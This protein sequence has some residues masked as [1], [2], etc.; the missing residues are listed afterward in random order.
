MV[1]EELVK[2]GYRRG[3]TSTEYALN[4]LKSLKDSISNERKFIET[5]FDMVN[6]VLSERPS[7]T[8]SIN[9]LRDLGIYLLNN[10]L[11][12][13]KIKEYLEKNEKDLMKACE[14]TALIASHRIVNGD[15]LMTISN[16][17]CV[18][19]MFKILVDNNVD[20]KVYV[21]ESRPGMEG[22]DLADYLDKLGVKT[23]L[24]IDSAARF[25]I[26]NVK[27]VVIGVEALAVNGAIVGKIG[28]SLLALIANE[29][30]V[31]VFALS[32]LYKLG[33][34]T[35]H[36]ELLELPEG[37]ISYLMSKDV[38][39][40]LPP[41]YK[42]RVPLFDVTPPHLIDGIITENGLFASQAIPVV[43]RQI[44]GSYPPRIKSLEEIMSKI[45]EKWG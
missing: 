22:L 21:L 32:P 14:E 37:D 4:I 31:R 3:L 1:Y 19:K 29:A 16:S 34:E 23:Y 20:F 11:E 40:T 28:T 36:G 30:R 8:A 18:R 17:V 33:F 45:K 27:K 7:N 25:F 35:I 44:Y 43:L 41:N 38:R 9:I 42:A 39:D 24:I 5:Y 2:H 6:R 15:V 10:G 26:K 13:N 12:L